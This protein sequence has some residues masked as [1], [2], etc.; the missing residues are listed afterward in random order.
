MN[1]RPVDANA[2]LREAR[3]ESVPTYVHPYCNSVVDEEVIENAPTLDWAPVIH[4]AWL[5]T[6]RHD[7]GK[8]GNGEID[9][10]AYESGYC[11]GPRC[12]ICGHY[13][14]ANCHPDFADDESCILHYVCS[15]CGRTVER[16]EPYCHCGAKMDLEADYVRS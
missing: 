7:W 15:E 6:K 14:C 8:D 1:I 13:V 12:R 10:W 3:C 11:N 9:V 16:K 5:P 4:G 2:L